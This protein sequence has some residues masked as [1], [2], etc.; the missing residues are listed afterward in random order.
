MPTYDEIIFVLSGQTIGKMS[1]I[2]MPD[3][4]KQIE[5]H[6]DSRSITTFSTHRGNFRYKRLSYGYCAAPEMFQHIMRQLEPFLMV[7]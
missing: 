4:F 6:P 2:D 1:K 3:A 5:L 7:L